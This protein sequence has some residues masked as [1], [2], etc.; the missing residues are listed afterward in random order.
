MAWSIAVPDPAVLW[1]GLYEMNL[2]NE[3]MEIYAGTS[4]TP[5]ESYYWLNRNATS[6]FGPQ[7]HEQETTSFQ[8][9]SSQVVT[10]LITHIKKKK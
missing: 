9:V 10:V 7:K 4:Q 2:L 1:I 8:S 6:T 3:V 5:L